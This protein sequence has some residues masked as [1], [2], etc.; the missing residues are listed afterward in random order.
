M[1]YQNGTKFQEMSILLSANA[2]TL[3]GPPK[4]R[5]P[6]PHSFQ[7]KHAAGEA[8]SFTTKAE[9]LRLNP[10]VVMPVTLAFQINMSKLT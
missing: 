6:S 7:V 5:H 10:K 1:S 2:H 4:C 8:L 3:H 9:V